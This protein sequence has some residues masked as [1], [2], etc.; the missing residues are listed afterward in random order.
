RDHDRPIPPCGRI[1]NGCGTIGNTVGGRGCGTLLSW[2]P[3]FRRSGAPNQP[4][5]R[6]EMG[7]RKCEELQLAA[8]PVQTPGAVS[9]SVTSISVIPLI[10]STVGLAQL[11]R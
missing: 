3:G 11:D 7:A 10:G 6:R 8:V 1:V 2:N 5:N 4:R 9:S